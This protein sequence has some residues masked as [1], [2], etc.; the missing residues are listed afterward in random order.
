MKQPWMSKGLLISR[1]KSISLR[2]EF[3][4]FPTNTNKKAYVEYRNT[5]NKIKRN[6]KQKFYSKSLENSRGNPRKT[7]QT[8][9]KIRG[10]KMKDSMIDNI[11]VDNEVISDKK[12]LLHILTF[13]SLM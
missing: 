4:R 11:T 7:W 5:F 2:K 12:K 1:N 3:Q 13:S 10:K 9:N 8:L 6:A